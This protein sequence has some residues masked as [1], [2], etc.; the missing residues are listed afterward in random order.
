MK[1]LRTL[2]CLFVLA[3]LNTSVQAATWIA[4]L[5]TPMAYS[6]YLTHVNYYIDI[7]TP[8][9]FSHGVYTQSTYVLRPMDLT[10]V[11]WSSSN[12]SPAPTLKAA[13]FMDTRDDAFCP[14]LAAYDA[15]SN[16][17]DWQCYSVPIDVYY[18]GPIHGC[19]WLISTHTD[20]NISSIDGIGPYIGP[21]VRN[22]SCPPVAVAPY[23]VSWDESYVAHNKT[24]RLSGGNGV[25]TQTLSTYL[26]KD[27]QLC[28]GSKMDD[29]GA[30]CR[31]VSQLMTFTASG[32]DDARVSVTSTPR[33]VGD[34]KLHDMVLQ[35][36]TSNNVPAIAATCRFQYILNEL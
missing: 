6:G 4:T 26:M 15:L 34:K 13:A 14:G 27:G 9:G 3:V 30:Y 11:S 12:G 33:S 1:L 31:I 29:R 21:A 22:S 7:V 23:D 24:V 8:E 2:V 16:I 5:H 35:V 25:V 28:D 20:S 32:C 17:S 10:L 36:N 19:P 18:D